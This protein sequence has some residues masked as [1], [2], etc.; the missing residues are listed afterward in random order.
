MPSGSRA[1]RDEDADGR[2]LVHRIEEGEEGRTKAP[3][4]AVARRMESG[5][6]AFIVGVVESEEGMVERNACLPRE[7]LV[8]E[9]ARAR[10][11]HQAEKDRFRQKRYL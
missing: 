2:A 7:G 9:R 1:A 8:F 11:G 10:K 5:R 6:V 4:G 3:A